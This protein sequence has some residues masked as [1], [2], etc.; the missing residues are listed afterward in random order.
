VESNHQVGGDSNVIIA[1]GTLGP[2]T[3]VSQRMIRWDITVGEEID[4]GV[5]ALRWE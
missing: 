5:W 4:L 3:V 2:R 1:V